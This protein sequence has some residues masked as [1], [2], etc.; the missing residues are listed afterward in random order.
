MFRKIVSNL[1]FSP[2]LVGQLSFY[3]K[4][5]RKEEFTRR[6]GLIFTALALAVQSLT[7]FVP[8]EAANASTPGKVGDAPRCEVNAVGPRG[9]A[10]TVNGN[11]ATVSFDVSGG[12]NC[13]VQV[14]ANAFY[15]PSMD[16]R[17][18]DKQ[19]LFHRD[20]KIFDTPGRKTM[21]TQI[22]PEGSPANG[23]FYQV[24][25]TYGTY[26]VTPVLAYG[27]GALS[28]CGGTF[29]QPTAF[30]YALFV[31]KLSDV[32]YKFTGQA[33]TK[34]GGKIGQYNF[35]MYNAAG[36]VVYQRDI[37]SE[38]EEVST[39]YSNPAP[40]TYTVR[41]TIT[42]G[43]NTNLGESNTCEKSFTVP[44]TPTPTAV[45]V[46]ADAKLINRN[47]AYFTGTS[48]VANGAT[49]SAYT[50]VVKDASGNEVQRVTVPSSEL[51]ASTSAVSIANPGDYQVQLLVQTSLGERTDPACAAQ[52]TVQ[53]PS[54]CQYNPN[55]PP[56]DERCQPC[57]EDS[58]VWID[59]PACQT[60]IV[61][62]KEAKNL[63]QGNVD[64]STVTAKSGDKITYTI[65]VENRGEK[66]AE[67]VSIQE[68]LKDV[69]EYAT[70]ID[71][72]TGVLDDSTKL[73]T[74]PAT[75]IKAKQKESRTFVV[76]I[77]NPVPVTNT[78]VTDKMSFD[79]IM[80][81]TFGNTI[82]VSV[83]CPPEKVIVEQVVSELPKTGPRENMI[84]AALLA[85]VVVYF[86]ARSRQ[87][88]KE[89]RLIRRDV[90]AG[91]I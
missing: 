77:L 65:V 71:N 41:L 85:T 28:G 53:P 81:N 17:P 54:V 75:T 72:G 12:K 27:H 86:W 14:S 20:T 82:D 51:T 46:K 67:N 43:A 5:L 8:P 37:A 60:T 87:L 15:A 2:A 57:T 21:T 31:N 36:A 69:L 55:L 80:T 91:A 76:Q 90:H 88:G 30:C 4:R 49:V 52:F 89:V 62:S 42:P 11:K 45:C 39:N 59:D 34:D 79:C 24:D 6:L 33:R 18:Y 10:F 23:C 63:V 25:L 84:F 38:N 29:S 9:S 70:L 83:D 68:D 7:V 26:N 61:Q 13:K 66:D 19:K 50:F 3:A 74:W 56:G 35:K 40:G 73:L 1:P 47:Q 64:A 58:D 48:A 32:D 22:P 16:G 78:G 44:G